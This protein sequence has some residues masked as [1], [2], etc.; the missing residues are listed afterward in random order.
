M[1][2]MICLDSGMPLISGRNKKRSYVFHG[3]KVE[4]SVSLSIPGIRAVW[5]T[6]LQLLAAVSCMLHDGWRM[7]RLLIATE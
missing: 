7:G 1:Y 3:A 2:V 6:I 4:S 5:P